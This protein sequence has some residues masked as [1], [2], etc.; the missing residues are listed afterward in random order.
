[1]K[2]QGVGGEM[3]E[4]DVDDR[5]IGRIIGRGGCNIRDLQEGTKCKIITPNKRGGEL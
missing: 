3:E 5:D 1:M 2:F 4:M